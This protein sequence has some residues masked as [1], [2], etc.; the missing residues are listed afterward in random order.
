MNILNTD[1]VAKQAEQQQAWRPCHLNSGSVHCS[2]SV[3]SISHVHWTRG[4]HRCKNGFRKKL[5]TGPL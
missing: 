4:T 1:E 2:Q 3:Q 5:W